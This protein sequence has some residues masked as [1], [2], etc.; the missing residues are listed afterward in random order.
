M[1]KNH[2]VPIGGLTQSHFDDN[3][4]IIKDATF[5][6]LMIESSEGKL[7]MMLMLEGKPFTYHAEA[8]LDHMKKNSIPEIKVNGGGKIYISPSRKM[9]DVEGKSYAFGKSFRPEVFRFLNEIFPNFEISTDRMHTD[10]GG[11]NMN[12]AGVVLNFEKVKWEV[13]HP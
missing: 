13:D 11:N 6:Y 10:P 8:L 1:Q 12:I 9:I 7:Q 4:N 3:G 5:K 2:F